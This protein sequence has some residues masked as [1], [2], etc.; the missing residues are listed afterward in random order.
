MKSKR[1]IAIM[2]LIKDHRIETQEEL[3]NKLKEMGFDV[4][5]A[6]ISRDIRELNLIKSNGDDG[7]YKYRVD[8]M[9]ENEV[10][11]DKYSSI[12]RHALRTVKTAQNLVVIKTYVGMGNAVG[13]AVD[14]I[15]PEGMLGTVAGDDT[16]L[17]VAESTEAAE[18]IGE[19]MI[20]YIDSAE[21]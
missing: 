10:I 19:E 7:E 18:N 14:S 16:V 13:A 4:T 3:Q 17:V 9:R 20:N 8:S 21:R 12:L 1:H 2:E 6:T 11:A 5:Q 15:C